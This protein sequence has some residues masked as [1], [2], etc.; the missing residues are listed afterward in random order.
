M[1]VEMR[2]R[3]EISCIKYNKIRMTLNIDDGF[4]E[5]GARRIFRYYTVK[6]YRVV[7]NREYSFRRSDLEDRAA[8]V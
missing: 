4:R 3:E 2:M 8:T 7:K 1:V 6:K 5:L